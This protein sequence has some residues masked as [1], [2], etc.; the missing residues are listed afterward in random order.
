MDI[1]ISNLLWESILDFG[2]WS[3]GKYANI[4]KKNLKMDFPLY[5]QN[6]ISKWPQVFKEIVDYGCFRVFGPYF[7]GT[8]SCTT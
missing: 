4:S 8:S 3:N 6:V 1:L 7:I 5:F 2:K